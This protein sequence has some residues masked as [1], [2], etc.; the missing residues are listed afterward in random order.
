MSGRRALIAG[1]VDE[2]VNATIGAL[3]HD[4]WT[5][6]RVAHAPESR[7]EQATVDDAVTRLDGLDLLVA[8]RGPIVLGAVDEQPAADWWRIVD[9]NL[10]HAFRFVR[11][12]A[13]HLRTSRGS[14]VLVGSEWGAR[15]LGGGTAFS[16]STAG[17]VGL[18]RALA[19]ELAPVRVNLVA[20][21]EIESSDLAVHADAEGLTLDEVRDRHAEL[22]LLGRLGSPE[23]VASAVAF[24]SSDQARFITGQVLAPTGGRRRG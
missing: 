4:G 1:G 2:I 10:G 12:A 24:L 7:T 15:G 9:A 13:P 18:M 14:I 21:G 20:P 5:V 11:A 22:A 17:L 3:E 6:A 16:A 23:D 8:G 19:R